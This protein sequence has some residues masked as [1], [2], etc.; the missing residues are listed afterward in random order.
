LKQS[1]ID[2]CTN[3]DALWLEHW[4]IQK[5]RAGVRK[6]PEDS[7]SK[8]TE[9]KREPEKA[10][11]IRALKLWSHGNSL[12]GNIINKDF[13]AGCTQ[14]MLEEVLQN[15]HILLLY[16]S[17]GKAEQIK[18][19]F[20]S[21]AGKN[22]KVFYTS[23]K[24][25][26]LSYGKL[27]SFGEVSGYTLQATQPEKL[28]RLVGKPENPENKFRLIIDNVAKPGK[29][30]P[31]LSAGP[32]SSVMAAY[33]LGAL[34]SKRLEELVTWADTLLLD[35]SN[36]SLQLAKLKMDLKVRNCTVEGFNRTTGKGR[37]SRLGKE[38]VLLGELFSPLGE[39]GV[40]G[41][42]AWI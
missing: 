32:G 34:D 29:I 27:F 19:M 40:S 26:V 6:N 14:K 22:Q 21:G 39:A 3:T 37:I 18:K 16:T 25:P 5:K 35:L 41:T 28:S 1:E 9:S 23:E 4:I 11:K 20:V 42:E 33:D 12:N 38:K 8:G 31:F 10:L 36:I 7:L 15:K 17:N 13:L 2:G 30:A 24:K